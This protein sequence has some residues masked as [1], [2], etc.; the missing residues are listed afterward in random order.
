MSRAAPFLDLPGG[1]GADA[2]SRARQLLAEAG[3]ADIYRR[4]EGR[5]TLQFCCDEGTF[6]LKHHAGIGWGRLLEQLLRGRMPVVDAGPEYRALERLRSAD[7]P[8]PRVLGFGA[9]GG[10]PGRRE[11]F[12]VTAA[13]SGSLSL[14]DLSTDW[15]RRPPSAEQRRRLLEQVAALASDMH[16]AGVQHR[17]FYLDHIYCDKQS[18]ALHK[19]Y[20][21]RNNRQR[22]PSTQSN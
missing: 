18:T 21:K 8:C 16:R 3:P 12:L 20:Y 5:T 1:D 10:N 13:L 11:S 2:F 9:R 15:Q 6:F 14:A 7:V 22:R 19:Y 17:D 4:K